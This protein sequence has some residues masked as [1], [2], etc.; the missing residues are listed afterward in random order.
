MLL[1]MTGVPEFQAVDL[2]Q[3]RCCEKQC[4]KG[5][6]QEEIEE[7]RNAFYGAGSE[8]EQNQKCSTTSDSILAEIAQYCTLCVVMKYVRHVG[9]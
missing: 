9:A 6:S 8:T 5:I 2:M 4:F 1:H 3:K 7:M